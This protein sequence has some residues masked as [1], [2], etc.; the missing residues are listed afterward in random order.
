MARRS[1]SSWVE[2]GT[3]RR[4]D[5]G[6]SGGDGHWR[7]IAGN[8]SISAS[9]LR[10]PLLGLGLGETGERAREGFELKSLKCDRP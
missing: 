3:G 8:C 1:S 9:P 6:I 10:P 5:A 7:I 2:A 4:V